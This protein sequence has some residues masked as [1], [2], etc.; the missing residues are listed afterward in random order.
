MY[1]VDPCV[2]KRNSAR[3]GSPYT[4]LPRVPVAFPYL[5]PSSGPTTACAKIAAS[6]SG[7]RHQASDPVLLYLLYLFHCEREAVHARLDSESPSR[8]CSLVSTQLPMVCSCKTFVWQRLECNTGQKWSKGSST[9][10]S[11][12]IFLGGT[13][14]RRLKHILSIARCL[15]LH[16]REKTCSGLSPSSHTR[17]VKSIRKSRKLG[18]ISPVRK[19]IPG[20][21]PMGFCLTLENL[22]LS[23]LPRPSAPSTRQVSP[24]GIFNASVAGAGSFWQLTRVLAHKFMRY[25]N[26]MFGPT[27]MIFV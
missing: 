8:N 11:C 13:H 23:T 3:R 5:A 16:F 14:L 24:V 2:Q 17:D 22:S 4:P 7:T 1:T 21:F 20:S 25:I 12:E 26:C 6:S 9:D 18:R 19:S 27:W 10:A 15:L